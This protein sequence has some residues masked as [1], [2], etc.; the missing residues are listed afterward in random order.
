MS[1]KKQV[2]ARLRA[3]RKARGLTVA[4]LAE[5]FRDV[6]PDR[7]ARRL[8]SLKDLERTIR[9]H[10]AG[11]HAVGPRYRLL[12]TAALEIP[13]HDL[14]SGQ[15]PPAVEV[16]HD[17]GLD[18]VE[19]ARRVAASDVGEG[20]LVALEVAVDELA[21]AYPRS[22]PSELL[23]RTRRHLEYVARLMDVRMTLVQ[24]RRLVV[25]G[26]WLSLLAATCE[27]DLGHSRSAA[28]RLRTAAELAVHGGHPEIYAWTLETR[29]WEAVTGGDYREAVVLARGAQEAAPKGGSAFIQAT[30][31]EGRAWA[32]LGAGA[33]TRDALARVER[34]VAPM[35]MPERPEHHFRYDPA[36]SD[37]YMATTLSWL[38]DPAAVACARGVLGRL[39][40]RRADRPRRVVSARLDLALALVGAGQGDEAVHVALEAVTSGR[41]VPSNYWR[42]A[43]VVTGV[44]EL[45]VP[46]VGE[47]K[48]AYRAFCG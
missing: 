40:A 21:S 19:L 3:E 28:V 5:L 16:L 39:E 29:A 44:G 34:L 32:R 8:P 1:K 41:L 15:A 12:Y 17:D 46:E 26:G 9:G 43:E 31:Q 38:G 6:A 20:T 33:E 13:E 30:A 22:A 37:A 23:R 24:R 45:R 14:F 48:D 42:A 27:I 35:A 11:E 4:D 47:L 25:V 36:K 18:A 2:G 7:V 10:E